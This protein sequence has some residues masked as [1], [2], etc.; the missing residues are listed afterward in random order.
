MAP[1][2]LVKLNQVY[3]KREDQSPSGSVKDR[4]LPLQVENLQAQGF[5]QAVISST[6]NAAL[7]AIHFCH[8]KNIPLNIF[9]SP[10]VNPHKKEK[11]QKLNPNVYFTKTPIKEAFRFSKKTGAYLL[12]QSTDPFALLGYQ[13][14]GKELIHQLPKLTS[15]FFPVGSGTTL[16]GTYQGLLSS[17]ASSV[18]IFAL[19][20]ASHAP[21]ASIFDPN[22]KPEKKSSTD[23][24]S[25]KFLPLK[26]KIIDAINESGGDAFL[27]SEKK[28]QKAQSILEKNNVSTSPEGALAYAGYLKAK[29]LKIKLGNWPVVILTGQK[30]Q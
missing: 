10:K 16:L 13:S 25:V 18:K 12:R 21:I 26:E 8:Q 3:I 27:I 20:P 7:S 22:T 11:I 17:S 30:H 5:K 9:L 23:A 19:Q 24:L 14:L 28:L 1:T 2:D 4:A 15:L 6:G 29:A